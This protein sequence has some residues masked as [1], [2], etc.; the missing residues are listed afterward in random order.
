MT[1]NLA[2]VNALLA[3]AAKGDWDAAF[4]L[5][6]EDL[7]Y[8]NMMLPAAHGKQALRETADGLL[9]LCEDSEWLVLHEVASG[10]LVMNERVDRFKKDGVWTDLP[11]AGVFRVRDGLVCSWHDYFDLQTVMTAMFP[12]AG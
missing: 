11:V 4:A 2:V 3:V 1:D 5:V 6:T 10:D 7:E 12:E 9:S 8:Q